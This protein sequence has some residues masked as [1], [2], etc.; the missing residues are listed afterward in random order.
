MSWCRWVVLVLNELSG[1]WFLIAAYVR[2]QQ[3]DQQENTI[4]LTEVRTCCAYE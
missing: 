2:G 3:K 1:V 4:T